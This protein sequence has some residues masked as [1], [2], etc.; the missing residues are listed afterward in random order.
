MRERIALASLF[1]V[2]AVLTI[3]LYAGGLGVLFMVLNTT[4]LEQWAVVI[5]GLAIVVGVPTA[6]HL[7][8]TMG[9]KE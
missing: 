7:L 1:P 5:V 9:N 2:M 8:A 3:V 4:P 6:A